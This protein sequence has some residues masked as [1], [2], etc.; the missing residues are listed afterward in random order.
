MAPLSLQACSGAAEALGEAGGIEGL[1]GVLHRA[2]GQG[3]SGRAADQ[4]L[5]KRRA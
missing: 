1:A 3:L 4:A 5:A 2:I